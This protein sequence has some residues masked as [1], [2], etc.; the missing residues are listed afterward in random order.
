MAE[1]LER[2]HPSVGVEAGDTAKRRQIVEGARRVFRAR[3][4]DGASMG[5]IARAAGVSKGTLYVYF[6]SKQALFYALTLEEKREQAEA[7]F[8]FNA[9]DPDVRQVLR[10]LGLSFF[11]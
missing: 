4:F 1:L 5:E 10:R 9:A 11:T 3:G 8:A 2:N 6:D 7:L